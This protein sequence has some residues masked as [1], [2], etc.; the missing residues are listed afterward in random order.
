MNSRLSYDDAEKVYTEQFFSGRKSGTSR[1][2]FCFPFGNKYRDEIF[3]CVVIDKLLPD[4]VI[5]DPIVGEKYERSI[6]CDFPAIWMSFG[7][8]TRN[9]FCVNFNQKFRM[10]DGYHRLNALLKNKKPVMAWMPES[11]YR[12]YLA[13]R[14]D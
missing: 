2:R 8:K 3:V 5:K 4:V 12:A 14:G 11:H 1:K 6:T 13:A 7:R 9:G 10:L